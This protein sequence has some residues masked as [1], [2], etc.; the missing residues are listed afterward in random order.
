MDA[1]EA[2]RLA[3]EHLRGSRLTASR[4]SRHRDAWV[5]SYVDADNPDV[6]L[7]GGGLIV[8]M[9]GAVIDVSSVPGEIDRVLDER[10]PRGE[11][12]DL[13]RDEAEELRALI[14]ARLPWPGVLE[15]PVEAFAAV[16]QLRSA[17]REVF[18]ARGLELAAL[19]LVPFQE[20]RVVIV[21]LDP[22]PTPGHAMGLAF[23]VPPEVRPLPAGVRSI[24][25]AM[26]HDGFD[27]PDHGDLSGWARQGVLLLNRAL[28]YERGRKAGAHLPIWR[29]FTDQVIRVLNERDEPVVFVLWGNEAQ[30]V[31]A[32][33]DASHHHTVTAPHPSSRGAYRKASQ[34]AGTFTTVNRLLGAEI[35]WEQAGGRS[36]S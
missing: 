25:A 11:D 6:M 17:G 22:Y 23:S 4:A 9:D 20:V 8:T 12:P 34:D 21:G 13:P 32:L 30:K 7:D 26:R 19:A 16:E 14:A 27:P 1:R 18:P 2:K 3:N 15:E 31:G 29:D 33:V 5:V 28:T 24:H 36:H 35:H 10:A